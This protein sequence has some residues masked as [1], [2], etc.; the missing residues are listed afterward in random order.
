MDILL[1]CVDTRGCVDTL[2]VECDPAAARDVIVMGNPRAAEWLVTPF[3]V[4][5]LLQGILRIKSGRR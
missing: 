3:F 1:Q 4:P 5:L 2:K